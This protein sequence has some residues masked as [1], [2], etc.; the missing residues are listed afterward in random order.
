MPE[1]NEELINDSDNT[2]NPEVETEN[3]IDGSAQNIEAVDTLGTNWAQKESLPKEDN[4]SQSKQ[5]ETPIPTK[6]KNKK[7]KILLLIIITLVIVIAAAVVFFFKFYDKPQV[8]T[9][10]IAQEPTPTVITFKASVIYL[11]GNVSKL[12]DEWK[13]EIKEGDILS[14]GDQIVTDSGSRVVLELDEGTIIR[15]DENTNLTLTQL[16][17][18]LTQINEEV[19][20]MFARV[21]KDE[22]H[23]FVT[24]AGG[25]TIESLGTAFSVEK[26]DEDVNVKVFESKVIIKKEQENEVQLEEDREWNK[27]ENQIKTLDQKKLAENNFYEWSLNEEKLITP[28]PSPTSK[29]DPTPKPTSAPVPVSGLYL[30]ASQTDSGIAFS[31]TVN[32]VDTP[33][34]FKLVKNEGGNPVFP[35]D[36]YQYLTD[37]NTRSYTWKITDGKTWHFRVCQYLGGKCGVYSN[38]VKITAPSGSGE[39]KE[40]T[41]EVVSQVESITLTASKASD[42]KA[43]L[44]WTVSGTVPNGFKVV[45][46]KSSGPTYPTRD[47]DWAQW[48]SG[49]SREFDIGALQPGNTYHFRVCEYLSGTCGVYSN[50]QSL[51]F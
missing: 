16:Q 11:T 50:E 28:T 36:D 48:L 47:G 37:P 33:Q 39:T 7:R 22:S 46:S 5:Q 20:V 31:W 41:S 51:S 29:P 15:L 34:G 17:P 44:T 32:G 43:K 49:D 2:N 3:I 19:G 45:W 12:V 6:P 4:I 14:E 8:Q 35:G 24:V 9:E 23:K 25:I 38:D 27:E 13:V 1:T 21:V 10:P 18:G 30:K 40:K 26:D 42:E